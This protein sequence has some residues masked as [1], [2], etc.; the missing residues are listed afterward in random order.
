MT[1]E[2][3]GITRESLG[4]TGELLGIT[5]NYS[6]STKHQIATPASEETCLVV[7]IVFFFIYHIRLSDAG[8]KRLREHPCRAN[9]AR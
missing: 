8:V 6:V 3:L 7:S 5:R 9:N 2:L 4:T 1:R